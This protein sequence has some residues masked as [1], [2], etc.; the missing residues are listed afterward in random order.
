[1]REAMMASVS[2]EAKI[3]DGE[4]ESNSGDDEE[5]AEED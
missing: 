5:M 4:N 2:S 3:D 1:M